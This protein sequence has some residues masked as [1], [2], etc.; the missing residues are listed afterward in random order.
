V[1]GTHLESDFIVYFEQSATNDEINEF[2]R[3]VTGI[4]RPEQGPDASD[5]LPEIGGI[6]AVAAVDDHRGYAIRLWPDVAQSTREALKAKILESPIVYVVLENTVPD[7]IKEL[8]TPASRYYM[9]YILGHSPRGLP[10]N[11]VFC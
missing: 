7:E 8:P 2:L 6:S 9:F 11:C 4:P 10:P 3:T 1:W 5:L